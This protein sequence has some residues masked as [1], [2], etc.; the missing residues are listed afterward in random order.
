[1][2]DRKERTWIEKTGIF[3]WQAKRSL[4]K[5]L[6]NWLA[7]N[8]LLGNL[9]R[10]G[11]NPAVRKRAMSMGLSRIGSTIDW[12]IGSRLFGRKRSGDGMNAALAASAAL[13]AGAGM[14]YLF[15]P[16][17]GACRRAKLRDG[18][19]HAINRTGAAA[20]STS[21]D[22]INRARGLVAQT[23]SIFRRGDTDDDTLEARVRSRMGRAVSHPGAIEVTAHDG[24]V[25]LSGAILSHEV[26]SMLSC[27]RATPGL[28]SIDNRLRIH[29]KSGD[30]PDLQGG[31]ERPGAR[32]ELMQSNWSP[33]TRLLTTLTGGALMAVCMRRKDALGVAAGTLG[34]GL[35]MR[36][37]TNLETR[38]IIGLG[39][40]RRAI[41]FHKTI[42]IDAPIER[43]FEFWKNTDNFPHFMTNV[44]E[45]RNLGEGRSQWT[46]AGPA[47]FSVKWN[48]VVTEFIPNKIIAW[49]S[50]PGSAVANAGIVRFDARDGSG[51]RV[52]IR[53]SYNPP[54]G[55]IGHAFAKIFGANPKREMDQD[56]LRMKTMI[57]TGHPPHDAAQPTRARVQ[58]FA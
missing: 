6:R 54:A 33:A 53:M 47:R 45:V 44:R 52:T 18:V 57:E 3:D 5:D 56:L 26:D 31:R 27:I 23:A 51:T 17:R 36:G 55:A 50:E 21:R 48:A 35:M 7:I 2:F 41:D 30:L 20:G 19:T 38:R 13:G 16:D 49:K 4:K 11:S 24:I 34:F 37:V 22:L 28:R 29:G 8:L 46:V 40:G 43:V 14:M 58:I 32:F 25:K 15:D 12:A 1:M 10:F 39:G 42:N 9:G